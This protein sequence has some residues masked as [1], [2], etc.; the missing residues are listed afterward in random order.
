L[1][2]LRASLA[3][4]VAL[5]LACAGSASAAV[6][7]NRT[8]G[9]NY[10]RTPSVVQDGAVTDL[11]YVRSQQPC[12]R[13]AGC[14]A[15]NSEYDLYLKQ[16]T[17]GGKDYDPEQLVANNPDGPAGIHRGRT[18]AATRAPDGTVYVFWASGANST[19]LYEVHENGTGWSAP[20][21]VPGTDSPSVMN[22]EALTRGTDVLLYTEEPG[23]IRAYRYTGGAA[24]G[25]TVVS[26]GKNIP[27]GIVDRENGTVR[28]TYVDATAYPQVD[29]FVNT[30]A[31]GMNFPAERRVISEPGASYWD[32]ALAQR[33]NGR[34][35][36]YAAPD[37]QEGAGRQQVAETDSNDFVRWSKPHDLTPG[38][39][40][41]TEYWDYWPEPFVLNNKVTLYYTS[42][43]ATDT[44]PT[45]TGHIW[46]DPGQGGN[47]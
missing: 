39:Q 2:S 35:E 33:D 7:Q 5:P 23:A 42:E 13:L 14:D 21:K 6:G 28:L 12:N 26:T 29:V 20:A 41:G 30:S 34:Y 43:R 1:A 32:P 4:A 47:G 25:G 16:S 11:F 37:R 19:D 17:N 38:F 45:G 8:D 3:L 46:T 36:L 10:D 44:Q 9:P 31:D 22:V 18:I 40:S 15:D 27:K 24:V